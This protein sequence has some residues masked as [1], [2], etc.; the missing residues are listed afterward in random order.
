MCY[1]DED[2]RVLLLADIRA[3]FRTLDIDRL[4]SGWTTPCGRSIAAPT[5]ISSRDRCHRLVSR[6]YSNHFRLGHIQSGRC[7]AHS[8][9]VGARRGTCGLPPGVS[10]A[11]KTAQRH[12]RARSSSYAAIEPAH[13]T[14]C[15]PPLNG[16]N[17]IR[18]PIG[19]QF[20]P[21]ALSSISQV[22]VFIGGHA[23][24]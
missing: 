8:R 5:T 15:S 19:C 16:W 17:N 12:N 13:S 4:N 7:N 23:Q 10:T 18:V 22:F 6:S 2:V 20:W 3:V 1:H 24:N 14:A 11:L 21:P 9:R